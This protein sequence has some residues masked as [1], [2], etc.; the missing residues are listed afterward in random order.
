MKR[1]GL[2]YLAAQNLRRKPFRSFVT[3]AIVGLAAGALFSATLLI[4]SVDRSLEVGMQRLGADL[5]VVPEG[6]QESGQAA[7]I[8]GAPASFYMD[9]SVLDQVRNINGVAQASPQ[10]FIESMLSSQCCTGHVQIVGYD[11][12]SDFVIGP[13]L[14][15]NLNRTLDRNEV[16]IGSLI[17][18]NKGE[19]VHFYGHDFDVAGVL[20]GTGMGADESVFMNIDTAYL[21]A[22]ESAQ[23]A[24]SP[25]DVKRGTISSVL[26]KIAPGSN[27]DQVTQ[28]IKSNVPGTM[29]ITANE[30]SRSV[31]DR[32]SGFTRGFIA[33]D[34]IVWVMSL[35]TIAAIFSMIVNER[36][37]E[38]GLLRAMGSSRRFV[39]R[40]MLT[41]AVF[42]TA[43]GGIAGIFVGGAALFIFK[44]VITSS[45]GIPYLWPP[46]W[47]FAMLMGGT[48]LLSII[49]GALASL[50]PALSSS[51]LEPYA[52]I[53]QGE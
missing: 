47:Y 31:T 49:S 6:S 24:E 33:I 29:V 7:L 17:L 27:I 3:I 45:L 25:L 22:E 36:Q 2:L 9:H 18:A 51:R 21:M 13:W 48:L 12:G 35:L 46:L 14:A 44:A 11:P 1:L 34:A 52:A 53:R 16:V 43:A 8:T 5:L 42:L 40:L 15:Q 32:L 41:E 19:Q 10:L 37:R 4:G 50:Y 20:D 38:I 23:V 28:R 30:L 26:V 39:F